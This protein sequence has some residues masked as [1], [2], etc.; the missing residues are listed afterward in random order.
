MW[1]WKSMVN[2]RNQWQKVKT[3]I[4]PQRMP[5][6]TKK[7]TKVKMMLIKLLRNPMK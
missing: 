2:T 4:K 5:I 1:E 3:R 6:K 7:Q